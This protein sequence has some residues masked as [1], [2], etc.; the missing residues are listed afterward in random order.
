M[1]IGG[2]YSGVG[3]FISRINYTNPTCTK[4]GSCSDLFP[5]RASVLLGGGELH[6][7]TGNPISR[8]L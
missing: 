6:R 4:N 3:A 8:E 7:N 1:P 2:D 5:L